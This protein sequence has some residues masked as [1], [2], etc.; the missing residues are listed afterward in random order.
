MST[1]TYGD[2]SLDLVKTN[3][4]SQ[5]SVYSEDGK[6][7]LYTRFV[8][9][10][11]CIFNTDLNGYASQADA[12]TV[13][14]RTL[15][16]PR[17]ALSVKIDGTDL[18]NI[19]APDFIG[20]PFPRSVV[21][22]QVIGS[23]LLHVSFMIEAHRQDCYNEFNE[24]I[25]NRWK[26]SHEYDV[27]CYCTRRID[28]IA[29]VNASKGVIPDYASLRAFVMPNVPFGFKRT[30]MSFVASS[31]GTRMNYSI[32]D[33]E[34]YRVPPSQVDDESGERV[35]ATTASAT[36][37]EY[38]GEYGANTFAEMSISLTGPKTGQKGDKGATKPVLLSLAVQIALSRFRLGLAAAQKPDILMNASIEE[39]LFENR[40]SLSLTV[41]R[42]AGF[43]AKIGI[44]DV[45]RLCLPTVPNTDSNISAAC[46]PLG[47]ALIYGMVAKWASTACA[48]ALANTQQSGVN[49]AV[50]GT[51]IDDPAVEV[52]QWSAGD[53]GD[54]LQTESES[55][56]SSEHHTSPYSE[57]KMDV[58]YDTN[59][60]ILH[61][62]VAGSSVELIGQ[63]AGA[64]L[65]AVNIQVARPTTKKIAKFRHQRFG[66]YPS[67][68]KG[69]DLG[70]DGKIL[71]KNLKVETPELWVDGAN[72]LHG[73]SGE[74]EF[75][76]VNEVDESVNQ[77]DG[78]KLPY[79]AKQVLENKVPT[80]SSS[81]DLLDY[82]DNM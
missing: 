8:M 21:I 66:A 19:G 7:Y 73:I 47:T 15:N 74:L 32:A 42:Q 40:V 6:D 63:S 70:V 16:V 57:T 18:I 54:A 49:V 4:I 14:R 28:G 29:V 11:G 33:E 35:G 53:V 24:I 65:T 3:S 68:P 71:V 56:T 37:R 23:S 9:D 34:Q 1:V 77:L 55:P 67:F 51:T 43:V 58:S 2:V 78:G 81:D 48:S 12:M 61:V 25:S 22:Q 27:N 38:S 41:R 52:K 60:N 69:K 59:K 79:D 72:H 20:G 26:V 31:D 45:S 44:F 17:Q 80:E 30:R 5:D 62:P 64:T 13:L 75:G 10:F 46:G 36:Y 39:D 82:N 50:S 76:M